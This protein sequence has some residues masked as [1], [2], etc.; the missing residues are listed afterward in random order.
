M[1]RGPIVRQLFVGRNRETKILK[2]FFYNCFFFVL[3]VDYLSEVYVRL[4]SFFN[5]ILAEHHFR[6]LRIC[7]VSFK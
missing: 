4:E 5:L 6:Q 1:M 3:P 7:H 2:M